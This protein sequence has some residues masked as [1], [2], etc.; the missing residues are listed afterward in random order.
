MDMYKCFFNSRKIDTATKLY[1]KGG[2]VLINSV[3]KT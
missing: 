2:G 1:M 3:K